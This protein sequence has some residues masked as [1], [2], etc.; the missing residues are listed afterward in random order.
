MWFIGL[1]VIVAWACVDLI[2]AGNV[3]AGLFGIVILGAYIF[4]KFQRR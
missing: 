1:I 4:W 2:R 3:G